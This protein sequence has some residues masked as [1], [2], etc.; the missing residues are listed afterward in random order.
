M[1]RTLFF[2]GAAQLHFMVQRLRENAIKPSTRSTRQKHWKC[3][4]RFCNSYKLSPL[5]CNVHQASCYIAFLGLYMKMSSVRTHYQS[6]LYAHKKLGIEAPPLSHPMLKSVFLGL[7]HTS[8][9]GSISKD[10]LRPDDLRKIGAVVNLDS[11]IEVLVWIAILTMFRA[12][13]RV[14]HVVRSDHTLLRS[15]IE[16]NN[17]GILIRVRSAKNVRPSRSGF[18]IPLVFAPSGAL[19]PARWLVYLLKK[20]PKSPDAPLFSSKLWLYV[21][22]SKFQSVFKLL[23][24]RAHI[25]GN[26]ASHS[27]RRGGA[28]AMADLGVPLID[29][30]NRGLW[31]SDCVYKYLSHSLDRMRS[32]DS[33]F[34]SLF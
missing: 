34:S 6:V 5:P 11:E 31:S 4:V 13:L 18:M 9:T 32:V 12:L 3:Y 30:K 23:C 24:S 15:D 21:S 22:Y 2:T 1:T 17:W 16:V 26:F 14:S 7:L 33:T 10:P 28:S 19:C 27:L 8:D 29:I 25:V 20:F